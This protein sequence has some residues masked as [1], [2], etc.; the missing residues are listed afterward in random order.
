M[1]PAFLLPLALMEQ[2]A[3]PPAPWT[4]NSSYFNVVVFANVILAVIIII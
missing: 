2:A 3:L 4:L 1:F